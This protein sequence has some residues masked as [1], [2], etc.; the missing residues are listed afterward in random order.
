MTKQPRSSFVMNAQYI[1]D[2]SFESP[3]AP[4]AFLSPKQPEI[5]VALEIKVQII[6]EKTYEVALNIDIKAK[7]EADHLFIIELKYAGLFT[8]EDETLDNAQKEF[9]LS[10]KCPELIF[11]FARRVISDLTQEGGYPPLFLSPIDFASLY[12]NKKSEDNDKP[13]L[14]IN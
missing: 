12:Y 1:K 7:A 6:E 3:K 8:L 11:P 14:M 4:Q 5:E 9:I 13:D 10:V 2:L